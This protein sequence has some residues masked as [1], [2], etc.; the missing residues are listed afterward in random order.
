MSKTSLIFILNW[1]LLFHLLIIFEIALPSPHED[2]CQYSPSLAF[3]SRWKQN[4]WL[5]TQ[6]SICFPSKSTTARPTTTSTTKITTTIFRSGGWGR[7]I[8]ARLD[9]KNH[10]IQFFMM[11]FSTS[12]RFTELAHYPPTDFFQF[13]WYFIL[14][15]FDVIDIWMAPCFDSR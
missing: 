3:G 8:G 10:K 2:F 12:H 11:V 5:W 6:M 13:H 15:R 9:R 4:A 1:S 7:G 14:N